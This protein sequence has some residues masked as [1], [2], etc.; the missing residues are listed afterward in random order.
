MM[1]IKNDNKNV[2]DDEYKSKAQ[3]KI[4]FW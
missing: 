4:S 2:D 3:E 1:M